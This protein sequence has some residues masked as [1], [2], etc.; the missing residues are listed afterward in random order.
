MAKGNEG[1]LDSEPA[2][3]VTV[4]ITK[5]L[6]DDVSVSY[7]SKYG[8]S[9]TYDLKQY[10]KEGGTPGDISVTD[11][12]HVLDGEPSVYEN[13]LYY[14]FADCREYLGKSAVVEIPVND[15][16][17]YLGYKVILTLT[18]KEYAY[19]TFT[20]TKPFSIKTVNG[21]KY[22]DGVL[23]YSADASD[24]ANWTEWDGTSEISS[25]N[26][27]LYLRGNDNDVI[28]GGYDSRWMVESEGTVSCSGDIRSLLDYSDPDNT[29]M[30]DSCF[31][32]I[33]CDCTCLMEAPALPATELS[34]DCYSCMF[35]G[36]TSLVK[37]PELPAV[38]LANGCYSSMFSGCTSL[39]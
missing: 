18:V 24:T 16:A 10:I 5:A 19:L 21:G 33:F 23:Q 30:G 12:E 29:T 2:G 39:D 6:L 36:C 9:S 14:S 8:S 28:T 32:F 13:V 1:Y 31:W 38:T 7:E 34:T 20:G 22:W 3:P 26:N 27:V 35:E 11:E 37:A 15:A 4:T 17:N 25:V